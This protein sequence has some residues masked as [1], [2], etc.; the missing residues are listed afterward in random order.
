MIVSV[1]AQ[2]QGF[3]KNK[4]NYSK[5]DWNYIQSE[6]FDIYYTE[7]GYDLAL[8][9]SEIAENS[10]QRLSEHWNY[11][12]RNRIPLLLFNSH[13][14]FTQTNV[15]LE[16]LGE[17]TGGFTELFRNRVVI[18]WEGSLAKFRHVIHHELTHA[19]Y[20]DMLYGGVVESI[21]GREYMFQLPLWFAEGL[22]EHESQY[23]STEADMI[24]RDAIITG[25]LPGIHQIYGGYMVYKG[26]ESFF[27]FIQEEYGGDNRW[28]AGE[29]LQSLQM[30]KNLENSIKSV[31][32]K[33]LKELSKEWHRSLRSDHWPEVAGRE[34]S[35]DFGLKLTDHMEIRNY[36][37]VT[38][39]FNPT[40]DKIAFL[41]DRNGYKEI[42]L[43]SS[44]DG[45]ILGTAI[46][47]EKAGDYEE[48]HWL[49]GGLGW[50]SDGT[51]LVFATKAGEQDAIHLQKVEDGG[52]DKVF[53]PD[54]DA[55]YSPSC[56]PDGTKI[57]FSGLSKGKLDLYT[58]DIETEELTRLTH[59]FFDEVSA[60]WSPDGSKIAFASDRL[61]VP[62][63]YTI[64]MMQDSYD[65]FTMNADGSDVKRIT[66]DKYNDLSPSWAPDGE[67]LVFTSDRNGVNNLYYID[68]ATS[69]VTP[70]TNLLTSASSPEWS[71]DGDRIVFTS[72]KEGGWDVYIVKR[73][74]KRE[75]TDEALTPTNSRKLTEETY[76]S[77]E[78]DSTPVLIVDEGFGQQVTATE[79][80]PQPY[81]LKFSPDM[82][83]AFAS[84][85]TFYGIGGMGQV[86]LSDIMGN[87][88]I[89]IGANLMYTLEE[90]DFSFSYYNLKN[91]T[92][93]GFSAFHYK[94]YYRSYN[95]SIFS[96]RIYGGSVMAAHPFSK[97]TRL[98]N[99]LNALH[100]ERDSYQITNNYDYYYGYSP[101]VTGHEKLAG[102]DALTLKSELVH[103][104]VLW[105]YTGP[106]S[107]SRYNF[108]VEYAPPV[109]SSDFSF[110]TLQLDYRKY[111]R[112]GRR[113]SFVT[114]FSGGGSFGRDPRL[115]FLGGTDGW[116]NARIA[117]IPYFMENMSELFFARYP[118]PL[119]G[120]QFYELYGQRYFLTNFEFRF[121]F[122][123]Y[124]AFAWPVPLVIGNISGVL[125]TDIA[126]VWHTPTGIDENT[127]EVIYDKVFHGGGQTAKGNPYLDDIKLTYGFG[128]RM[129]LGFAI[130]RLDTAWK[131]NIDQNEPKPMFSV[132]MGP[133]F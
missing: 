33:S 105:N 117:R 73:P 114:R 16:I 104:T 57:L 95:W 82:V 59:D 3:G 72:F 58:I 56:S 22:A 30:T 38:P 44:I 110:T 77:A 14:D 92:N 74:L 8:I 76:A 71:P 7:D 79:I 93:L 40:G 86:A 85:N 25:Y 45:K 27:K 100:L 63:K 35:D 108:N 32:G 115:F 94:T 19:M 11:H 120:Y 9:A 26:G 125:F 68:L 126:S 103:D 21:V 123:D 12:P 98:D 122:V 52:Y 127:G 34:I 17:G 83:N 65:I 124:L 109:S 75:L 47:G 1:N 89:F 18:P 54:M 69:V 51:M 99:S 15:I 20:F 39:S 107:G 130:L 128:I 67:K 10:Y 4:V 78:P 37:N 119:R 70:L 2:A 132:A 91:Q 60:S 102:V 13:N 96:D 113:Y 90:S 49:R 24:I 55:I 5:F 66:T 36:L 87:H 111:I 84:Y 88:R 48:M 106:A 31:F 42:M 81:R 6:N 43:M 101:T 116:L 23:W 61:V 118:A 29:I 112:Y 133:E 41:T 131:T 97:F 46:R 129:N 53:K 80:S 64:D 62:Y 50:S 28:V 121:P